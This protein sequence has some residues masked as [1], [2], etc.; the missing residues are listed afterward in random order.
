MMQPSLFNETEEERPYVKGEL[1]RM[2]FHKETEQFSIASIKV[3]ETN[4]DF[5]DKNLV[6]KG[7]FS[8]RRRGDVYLSWRI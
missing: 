3:T 5:D 2:I 8:P 6:I 7:H 1:A 4:E